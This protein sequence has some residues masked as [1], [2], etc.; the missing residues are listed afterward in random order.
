VVCVHTERAWRD[1][2][3]RRSHTGHRRWQKCVASLQKKRARPTPRI[4]HHIS[5]CQGQQRD[6]PNGVSP[7]WCASG[8]S[9]WLP[10]NRMREPCTSGSVGVATRSRTS[11]CYDLFNKDIT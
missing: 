5:P 4:M 1:G 3:R 10:R 6:G 7:V 2:L 9:F 11:S 8:G